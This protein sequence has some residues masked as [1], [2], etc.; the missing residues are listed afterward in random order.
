[1]LDPLVPSRLALAAYAASRGSVPQALYDDNRGG[2]CAA[3]E[4]KRVQDHEY[5]IAGD[6]G[7]VEK[8]DRAVAR[9]EA[10]CGE[11][12]ALGRPSRSR[13]P[14]MACGT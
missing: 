2:G 14:A 12:K 1:M 6:G 10:P 4:T 7:G 3:G 9:P 8:A 5:G 11:R 13:H